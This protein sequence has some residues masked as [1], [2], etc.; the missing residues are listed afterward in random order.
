M[1]DI[2]SRKYHSVKAGLSLS[3][4]CLGIGEEATCTSTCGHMSV[5]KAIAVLCARQ[6]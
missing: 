5:S 3:A 1:T 4:C 6:G 2:V